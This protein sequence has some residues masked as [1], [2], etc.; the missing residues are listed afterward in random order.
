MKKL[1]AIDVDETLFKTNASVK[2]IE[3]GKVIKSL[4]NSEFNT[5]KLKLNQTFDFSE[6]E[7][8]R[9]FYN[10]SIPIVS[11]IDRVN[12]IY[13][14]KCRNDKIIILTA[15][16]D[17]DD[18]YLYLN[19]FREAGLRIDDCHVNR[20]GNNKTA[21]PVAEKKTL[22]IKDHIERFEFSEVYMYD[23]AKSNLELFLELNI[24]YPKVSFYAYLVQED[25]N[26][27][28]YK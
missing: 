12:A 15:R 26:V 23:D 19:K 7:N 24:E 5:Y 27:E 16:S 25:G 4:S 18:K 8:S 14:Y 9:L 28:Q 21:I 2:V 22:V 13:K 1:Y 20:A 3:D 6:F 11:M 17:M 10:E